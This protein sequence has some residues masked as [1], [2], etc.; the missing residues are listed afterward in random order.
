MDSPHKDEK[1]HAIKI[2]SKL[3]VITSGRGGSHYSSSPTATTAALT[4]STSS[5]T[6]MSGAAASS[7]TAATAVVDNG[8]L[9]LPADTVA[10]A[11][12][13]LFGSVGKQG[14]T[15]AAIDVE[16]SG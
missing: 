16:I 10:H 5:S 15:A 13:S 14:P 9:M 8:G 6:S 11:I 2:R 12:N 3:K 7:T 4:A 1:E